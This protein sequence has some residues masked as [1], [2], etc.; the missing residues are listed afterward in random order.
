M[1]YVAARKQNKDFTGIQ[2]DGLKFAA[3]KSSS[4]HFVKTLD[5]GII[6]LRCLMIILMG[7]YFC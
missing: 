7:D 3:P 4:M 5:D 2:G 6:V 1:H